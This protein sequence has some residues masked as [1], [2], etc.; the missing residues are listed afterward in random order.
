MGRLPKQISLQQDELETIQEAADKN[1]VSF[2]H[3]IRSAG[4]A[5]AKWGKDALWGVLP[6]DVWDDICQAA[7]T[8]KMT[9]GDFIIYA[10]K[11]KAADIND[12]F[13]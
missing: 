7:H 8:M 9:P 3:Y 13:L 11:S 6:K 4:M 1:G 10:A 2:S 12:R 5:R